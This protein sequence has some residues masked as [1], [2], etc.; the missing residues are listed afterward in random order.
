MGIGP[1]AGGEVRVWEQR[2]ERSEQNLA[3]RRQR[4]S[5]RLSKENLRAS[6]GTAHHLGM[7]HVNNDDFE[8]YY[9]GMVQDPAELER[10]ECHLLW[11]HR[12]VERA[13][14]TELYV[15]ATRAG[16]I[17]GSWDL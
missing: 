13:A 17:F 3:E 9:L 4:S 14:E 6:P 7:R 8:R 2:G 1:A 11:C 15:D 12:C 16:I 5:A 10:L